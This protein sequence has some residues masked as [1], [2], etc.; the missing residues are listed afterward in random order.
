MIEVVQ[1]KDGRTVFVKNG[2]FLASSFN[3]IKESETWWANC[4]GL[5][6]NAK[7]IFILGLGCGYHVEVAKKAQPNVKIVV[8]ECDHE[9][10]QLWRHHNPNSDLEI[11]YESDW[12]K[13]FSNSH[14]NS[15]IQDRY[16]VLSHPASLNVEKDYFSNIHRFLLARNVEGLFALLKARP[17]LISD[18][19]DAKL[20]DLARSSDPVSIKT[21]SKIMKP[22][23]YASENRRLWKVL[24][25]L[26]A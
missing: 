15:G 14:V 23:T 2:K 26:I 18:F 24:E 17:E 21:L 12:R 16:S 8:I 11:V 22:T 5:T 19:D 25:E 3:P 7:T 10:I 9:L 13:L 1:A 6:K 4:E 20:A